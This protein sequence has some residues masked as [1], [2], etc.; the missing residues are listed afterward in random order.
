[1]IRLLCRAGTKVTILTV[2]TYLL[3]AIPVALTYG[4]FG[5][6][7]TVALLLVPAITLNIAYELGRIDGR[8]NADRG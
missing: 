7:V 4:Q 5:V 6:W 2:I 8:D 3:L 1:M